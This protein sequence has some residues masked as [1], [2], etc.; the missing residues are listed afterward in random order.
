MNIFK[1]IL[2]YF[3]CV[4]HEIKQ[5]NVKAGLIC[6]II[7]LILGIVSW[8]IGGK[9]ANVSLIFIFPRSALPLIYAF[10]LWGVSFIFIGFIIGG[11]L[12]SCDKFKRQKSYRPLLFIALMQLVTLCVYPVFFGSLSPF[13]SFILLLIALVFCVFSIISTFKYFPFWTICL[14]IHFLW[15]LYNSYIALA[16]AF[17][18]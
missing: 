8:V 9:T 1:R 15:L 11:L 18:N 2:N 7:S 13:I 10:I 14:I 5:I 4:T 3:D 16:F 6:G 17:V 12:F